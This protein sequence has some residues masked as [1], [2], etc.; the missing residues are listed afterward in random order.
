MRSAPPPSPLEL[1]ALTDVVRRRHRGE[2]RSRVRR[3]VAD[4]SP[5]TPDRHPPIGSLR[6]RG[7][8]AERSANAVRATASARI[9]SAS[10]TLQHAIAEPAQRASRTASRARAPGGPVHARTVDLDDQPLGAPQQVRLPPPGDPRVDLGLRQAPCRARCRASAARGP[11]AS[12]CQRGS[13]ARSSPRR[14][15]G[16]RRL[17]ARS[18]AAI[19]LLHVDEPQLL[20]TDERS[21]HVLGGNEVAEIDER[22]REA[23][24][25]EA[26]AERDVVDRQARAMHAQAGPRPA[27]VPGEHGDVL[28]PPRCDDG[29]PTPRRRSCGSPTAPG[30]AGEDRGQPPSRRRAMRG[31]PTA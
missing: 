10:A 6:I 23:G 15:A 27:A 31:W 7:P 17:P 11:S 12:A 28:H 3:R 16:P 21:A 29:R 18:S 5:R 19:D 4:P 26:V 8:R 14:I 22:A 2:D 1:P 9:S 24:D 25:G 13:Y 20:G 30:P